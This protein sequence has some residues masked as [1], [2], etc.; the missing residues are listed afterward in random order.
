MTVDL[1]Q[2]FESKKTFCTDT[3]IQ[4]NHKSMYMASKFSFL[5]LSTNIRLLKTELNSYF[6]FLG[7]CNGSIYLN[8]TIIIL[9]SNF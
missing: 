9:I 8:L 3:L 1:K 4:S 7:D 6:L 5:I 2:F